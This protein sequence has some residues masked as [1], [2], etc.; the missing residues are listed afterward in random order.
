MWF[1]LLLAALT[2]PVRPC[3][4]MELGHTD[5]LP[6]PPPPPPAPAPAPAPLP[7]P[8]SRDER[9]Q[10]RLAFG[11]LGQLG[12]LTITIAPASAPASAVRLVGQAHGSLL[13][14]GETDKRLETELEPRSL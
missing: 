3:L 14:L 12:S 7:A 11:I 5:P 4:P 10:Y 1:V 13:G 9:A 6:P 8:L 2:P